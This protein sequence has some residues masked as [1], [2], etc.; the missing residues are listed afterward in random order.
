MKPTVLQRISFIV[1][2]LG[3]L[4]LGVFAAVS[5]LVLGLLFIPLFLIFVYVQ[6]RAM[7]RRMKAY[8]QRSARRADNDNHTIEGEVVS[9]REKPDKSN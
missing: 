8:E 1:I 6:R 2:T 5:F 9:K 7:L 4:L 3:L